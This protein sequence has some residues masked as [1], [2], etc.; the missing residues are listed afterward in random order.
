LQEFVVVNKVASMFHHEIVMTLCSQCIGSYKV[1]KRNAFITY[2]M[3]SRWDPGI[4]PVFS[5]EDSTRFDAC[6]FL[7]L[8]SP[9]ADSS[10]PS[11]PP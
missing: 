4:S 6:A 5:E 9:R 7:D 11:P 1:L 10:C 8:Q 2:E 3:D